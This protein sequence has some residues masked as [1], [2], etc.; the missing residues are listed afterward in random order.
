MNVFQLIFQEAGVSF[1]SV[2]CVI[3][4]SWIPTKGNQFC[5]IVI[6]IVYLLFPLLS[7]KWE[8]DWWE[9]IGNWWRWVLLCW[10]MRDLGGEKEKG[11][12]W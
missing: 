12:E 2:L 7:W 11:E 6:V 1:G 4:G 8:W 5:F 10:W 9:C 3:S